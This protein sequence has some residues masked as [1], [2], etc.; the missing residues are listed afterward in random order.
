MAFSDFII[1]HPDK[2]TA[3]SRRLLHIFAIISG[4]RL[5]AAARIRQANSGFMPL[6]AYPCSS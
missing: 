4:K 2:Q 1:N 5:K 3:A 6:V